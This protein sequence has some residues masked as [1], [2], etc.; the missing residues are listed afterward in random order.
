M[1]NAGFTLVEMVATLL[2][3]GILSIYVMP[4]FFNR[5]NFEA[6]GFFQQTQSVISYAQKVAIAQRRTVYVV[7]ASNNVRACYDAGC[8]NAV[9]G[10]PVNTAPSGVTLSPATTFNFNGLG[11]SS[12]ASQ[13]DIT[14]SGDVTRH[15]YIESQTGYV[16]P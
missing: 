10:V 3:V 16:H 7:I 12:L 14:V 6:Q 5:L 1:R 4:R 13:L 2:I 15:L 11:S 9:P 8:T